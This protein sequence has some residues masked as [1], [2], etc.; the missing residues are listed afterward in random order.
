MNNPIKHS[1]LASA[2]I[3]SAGLFGLSS[4]AQAAE[5]KGL[6]DDKVRIGVLADMG[7]PYGDLCGK[8]CVEAV[9]MAVEDFGGKAL[10][11]PI[12]VVSADDQNKPDLGSAKAREWIESEGVDAINGLVASSVVGAVAQVANSAETPILISG[13]GSNSFTTKSCSPFNAHWT[14][15][16]VALA[17]GTVTP[18]VESGKKKWFFITADYAFGHA[19]EKVATGIIES[20][21]GEV[22]GAARAPLGT[23][24]YS[25]FVLQ[26]MSS[27]ADA[28]ALAN[29]GKD[30]VNSLKAATEFGL[31]QQATMVGLLV[32]ASDTKAIDP[33]VIG[34]MRLTTG[35]Y[36]DRDAESRA[37][38]KRF[39]SR[40]GAIPT[41]AH[42]GAY[43]STLHYLNAVKATGTDDGK[44]VMKEMKTTAP[45][46]LFARNATLRPD[47]RMEHDMYQV[48]VK[49][50]SERKAANDIYEI[51]R[52][53]P[54]NQ[55]FAAMKPEC[56]FI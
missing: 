26:A 21:G 51:E 44:V 3:A 53:I 9:R 8:N 17:R 36:W 32:F 34:D 48:R 37:W 5:P 55:A 13:A 27:G 4:T 10:G 41:M 25:S 43:S 18:L 42:A 15:D 45:N 50:P 40:T 23:T 35:F 56:N 24:D 52:V 19:L 29:A 16:V 28:V 12:E 54:G 49:K 6:S 39:E 31:S 7:G 47:G 20:N 38:A 1:L 33:S 11:K 30:F 22:V 14:Y 46:D 2:L